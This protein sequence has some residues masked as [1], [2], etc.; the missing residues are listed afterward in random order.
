MPKLLSVLPAD[1][2]GRAKARNKAEQRDMRIHVFQ[3]S[4]DL[5]L[6][7][8][9]PS[10]SEIDQFAELFGHLCPQVPAEVAGV[11]A[12]RLIRHPATPEAV[13]ALLRQRG[14]ISA[15]ALLAS[16]HALPDDL[17][18]SILQNP[19][20]A[21]AASL[22]RRPDLSDTNMQKLATSGN[23][24]VLVALAQNHHIT[25][26]DEAIEHL[27]TAAQ[28]YK[29]LAAT[30]VGRPDL[31]LDS[32]LYLAYERERRDALILRVL[33]RQM[34]E[35]TTVEPIDAM[36]QAKIQRLERLMIKH[37]MVAAVTT[38]AEILHL[39]VVKLALLMRDDESDGM[40]MALRA[41]GLERPAI[42]RVAL[43][44]PARVA[45]DFGE[46][47]RI[48]SM[49]DQLTVGTA[50]ALLRDIIGAPQV[51]Q[52]GQETAI[53]VARRSP[54]AWRARQPERERMAQPIKRMFE[55]QAGGE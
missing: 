13:I 49:A 1:L 31:G 28:Q 17:I 27:M 26:P 30:L 37:D 12:A 51:V 50:A 11:Q 34:G 4:C 29:T 20:I 5:F 48:A 32:R 25:L 7:Q 39:P 38:C 45:Q 22:A 53:A 36:Q 10:V 55:R 15:E 54:A 18:A 43:S 44:G 47:K 9:K 19:T 21:L 52:A 35:V 33:R 16:K 24:D 14:L 8:R 23:V 46:I 2:F 40:V 3:S 6:M 42:V 41:A